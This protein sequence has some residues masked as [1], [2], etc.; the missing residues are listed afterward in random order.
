MQKAVV[1]VTVY[2][3][4]KWIAD[5]WMLG[6]GSYEQSKRI[7]HLM[8]KEEDKE[9]LFWKLTYLKAYIQGQLKHTDRHTH[10]HPRQY[11]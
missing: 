10:T 4:C 6:T 2:K 11:A 8:Y 3:N 5:L 1:G 9:R 7:K